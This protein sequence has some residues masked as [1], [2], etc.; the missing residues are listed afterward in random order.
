VEALEDM[1]NLILPNAI[2]EK[3]FDGNEAVDL[4]QKKFLR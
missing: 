4:I 2:I 3:A 1:V